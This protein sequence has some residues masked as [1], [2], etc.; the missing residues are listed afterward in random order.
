MTGGAVA[1]R[2]LDDCMGF[3]GF[4]ESSTVIFF[5]FQ[6]EDGIRDRTVTGVQT[7]ALPISAPTRWSSSFPSRQ[8]NARSFPWARLDAELGRESARAAHPELEASTGREPVLQRLVD[9]LDPC[10]LAL[11]DETEAAPRVRAD[12]FHDHL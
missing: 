1:M 5:F 8:R 10:A 4:L 11:E 9:V 12:T 6:A 7:C 2:A 3:D